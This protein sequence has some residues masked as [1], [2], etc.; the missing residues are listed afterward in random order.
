MLKFIF[1]SLLTVATAYAD[2]GRHFSLSLGCGH[3]AADAA[4]E[5]AHVEI[6]NEGSWYIQ[7]FTTLVPYEEFKFVMQSNDYTKGALPCAKVVVKAWSGATDCKIK[8]VKV[9]ALKSVTH[10]RCEER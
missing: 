2:S 5:R 1:M 7:D 3:H 4:T 9:E 8:S 6:P 10:G